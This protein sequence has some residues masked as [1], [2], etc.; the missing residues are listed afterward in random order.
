MLLRKRE[1]AAVLILCTLSA[2]AVGAMMGVNTRASINHD[3]MTRDVVP[4]VEAFLGG[5]SLGQDNWNVT[6]AP[7]DMA[8]VT[9]SYVYLYRYNYGVSYDWL[10]MFS[11]FVY[12]KGASQVYWCD[13][14]PEFGGLYWFVWFIGHDGTLMIVHGTP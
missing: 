2:V 14:T 12:N 10:D 6:Y 7:L 5:L 8:N 3:I 11:V 1:I 9:Q 13:Y 4:Y